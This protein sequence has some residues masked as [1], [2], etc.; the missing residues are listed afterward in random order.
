M[1]MQRPDMLPR[2]DVLP[3]PGVFA[4]GAVAFFRG[5][6]TALFATLS[7]AGLVLLIG[8][9]LVLQSFRPGFGQEPAATSE[10]LAVSRILDP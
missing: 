2:R 9:V 6:M 1:I 5:V 3:T 4:P 10:P 7:V 8:G